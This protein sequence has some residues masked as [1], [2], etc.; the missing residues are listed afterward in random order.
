MPD[1]YRGEIIRAYVVTL[2][3]GDVNEKLLMDHCAANLVRY[4]V[5]AS[6][7]VVAELPKTSVGK[8]DKVSLKSMARSGHISTSQ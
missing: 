5:P 3:N 4:K 7:E 8:L 1:S 2:R 6:I